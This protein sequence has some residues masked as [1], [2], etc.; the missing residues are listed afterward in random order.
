MQKKILYNVLENLSTM[1]FNVLNHKKILKQQS[2]LFVL[3]VF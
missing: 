3:L 1:E 2:R